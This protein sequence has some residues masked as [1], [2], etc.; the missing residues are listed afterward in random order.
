MEDI[1]ENDVDNKN[2]NL[3]STLKK[4][5][6]GS[7]SLIST[8][9]SVSIFMIGGL[10]FFTYFVSIR[11][12]PFFDFQESIF[13]FIAVAALGS[14]MFFG[15][16]LAMFFPVLQWISC[17]SPKIDTRSKMV[18]KYSIGDFF[19]SYIAWFLGFIALFIQAIYTTVGIVFILLGI[20][21]FI[22]FTSPPTSRK[23]NLFKCFISLLPS[24][25][26]RLFKYSI[27]SLFRKNRKLFKVIEHKLYI[28]WCGVQSIFIGLFST[29]VLH[30][31][32][33]GIEQN[34]QFSNNHNELIRILIYFFILCTFILGMSIFILNYW[35]KHKSLGISKYIKLFSIVII[36][37]I[38]IPYITGS[39]NAIPY[40]VMRNL[41]LGALVDS[42]IIVNHKGCQIVEK[43]DPSIL[44]PQITPNSTLD[45]TK[46]SNICATKNKDTVYMIS[47]IDI[48]VTLG[49]SLFLKYPSISS[50]CDDS[51]KGN[52]KKC[53][54]RIEKRFHLPKKYVLSYFVQGQDVSVNQP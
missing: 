38:F 54:S 27:I 13:I 26:I 4:D 52:K 42:S 12:M 8:V 25:K 32:F 23:N 43:I 34:F 37:S 45:K 35:Y 53:I 5:I 22:F 11:Y 17:Y 18:I 6:S 7:V 29:F 46:Q 39:A 47:N 40:V 15:Y 2:E 3:V 10:F 21:I 30:V 24:Q 49:D 51:A 33:I 1:K 14:F 48:Q 44:S 41:R 9:V 31:L 16:L 28:F 19:A 20:I 36:C 50:V